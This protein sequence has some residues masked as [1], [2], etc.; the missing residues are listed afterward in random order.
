MKIKNLVI[1]LFCVLLSLKAFAKE[2]NKNIYDA[3]HV[4]GSLQKINTLTIITKKNINS[5]ETAI[6]LIPGLNSVGLKNEFYEWKNF[7]NF[8]QA[9]KQLTKAQK[10]K[11]AFFVFRY[12]GWQS[13]FSASSLLETA[14]DEL[15]AKQPNLKTITLIGYSQ[16]G[17]IARIVN[18]ESPSLNKKINKI[19]TLASPH[20]GTVTLTDSWT[21]DVLKNQNF[22]EKTKNEKVLQFLR[23]HYKYAYY[24]QA[25]TNF[26]DNMPPSANYKVPA[27]A[28]TIPKPDAKDLN[29]FIVYGS[30]IYPPHAQDF[31]GFLRVNITESILRNLLNRESSIN[32]LNRWMATKN[33]KDESPAFR[34]NLRLNDSVIPLSSSLWAK[35]CETNQKQP[36][37]W[38]K[39]FSTNN[40]CP[41]A[42]LTRAF[43]GFHHL[44]WR[45]EVAGNKKAKDLF[46]PELPEKPLYEW[47][48]SDLI[49]TSTE[50]SESINSSKF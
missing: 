1:I 43:Y 8:W 6:I 21:R 41:T 12:D 27:Q 23:G 46:Q 26:D 15:L 16:G 2:S 34:D 50:N 3:V 42:Y 44:A 18:Y 24:E 25:W 22:I 48:I 40:Y 13:L 38:H 4:T 30:Y 17:L 49:S 33:Y 20:R 10:E 11:Y 39:V 9:S 47:L 37:N 19:I 28:L 36:E 31:E 14:L 29:K 32:E 45:Q 7:W 5:A 35:V